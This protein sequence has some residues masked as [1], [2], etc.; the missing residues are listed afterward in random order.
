MSALSELRGWPKS[1]SF[2]EKRDWNV[3]HQAG[4]LIIKVILQWEESAAGLCRSCVYSLPPLIRDIREHPVCFSFVFTD[5]RWMIM[6]LWQKVSFGRSV[7]T[8]ARVWSVLAICMRDFF[9][10]FSLWIASTWNHPRSSSAHAAVSWLP[11]CVCHWLRL[12]RGR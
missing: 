9:V 1:F 7:Y 5:Q 6:L 12:S 10:F 2:E 11:I 8:V 4:W 3:W